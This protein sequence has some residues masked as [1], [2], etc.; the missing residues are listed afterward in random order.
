MTKRAASTYLAFITLLLIL[1]LG[2][3]IASFYNRA[4]ASASFDGSHALADV[5]TQL[6]FGPRVPYTDGHDKV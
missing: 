5:Q 6:A 4:P 3:Y 2:W 1:V